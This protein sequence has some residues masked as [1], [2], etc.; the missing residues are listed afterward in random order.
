MAQRVYASNQSSQYA[1]AEAAR[2]TL[3]MI[4]ISKIVV[5]ALALAGAAATSGCVMHREADSD[6]TDRHMSER[7]ASVGVSVGFANIGFGYNDGYWDN[8]RHWH[9]WAN[10]GERASY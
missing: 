7:D 9:H 2:R 3:R 8:T 10:D 4:T 5:V 1:Y 6:R